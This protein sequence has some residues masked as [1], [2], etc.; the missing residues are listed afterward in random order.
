[1]RYGHGYPPEP[2]PSVFQ[3]IFGVAKRVGRHHNT[4]LSGHPADY[5]FY[6]PTAKHFLL[7]DHR[8]AAIRAEF[9]T[10]R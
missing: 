9:P 2:E 5:V 3:H 8:G 7:H 4:R 10:R 6:L 1:M